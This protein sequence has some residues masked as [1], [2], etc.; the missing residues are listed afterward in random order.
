[1]MGRRASDR[2]R[3]GPWFREVAPPVPGM[4]VAAVMAQEIGAIGGW[5]TGRPQVNV[6]PEALGGAGRAA[7]PEKRVSGVHERGYQSGRKGCRPL[8]TLER[9]RVI[10]SA[11]SFFATR[12]C[13]E[14]ESS[15][16]THVNTGVPLS[17]P[18]IVAP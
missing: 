8:S 13:A 1:M 4:P 6:R 7:R 15:N 18:V 5:L 12:S 16:S 10:C 17:K 11:P 14:S 3:V 9:R 2:G